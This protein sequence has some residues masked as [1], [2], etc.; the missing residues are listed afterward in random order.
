MYQGGDYLLVT[1][2]SA[3]VES[4]SNAD[5]DALRGSLNAAFLAFA[6]AAG[7]VKR[8]PAFTAI[9]NYAAINY[10]NYQSLGIIDY[11]RSGVE[12]D[13][14]A[15]VETIV[16]N[17]YTTLTSPGNVLSPDVDTQGLIMKKYNVV[18]A[19][20]MSAFGVDLQAIGNANI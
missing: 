5:K 3:R 12:S 16:S 11:F 4:M 2:G 13:W 18:I 10:S 7:A 8:S 6:H 14:D 20:F 19:Y 1:Y 9:T 15:F 17:S